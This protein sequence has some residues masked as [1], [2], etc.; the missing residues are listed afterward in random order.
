MN[1]YFFIS[2]V[3]GFIMGLIHSIMGERFFIPRLF[4]REDT[5]PMGSEAYV[6]RN[7]RISWHLTTIAWWNAAAILLVFSF[8]ELDNSIWIVARIISNIFFLSGIFSMLGSRAR[9]LSWVVFFLIS[10]LA[11]WGTGWDLI[12]QQ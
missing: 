4:Q 7:T 8:R 6:N 2:A 1:I 12:Y 5:N 10:L 11:W 9:N 3:L